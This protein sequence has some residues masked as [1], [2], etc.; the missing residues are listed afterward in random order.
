V[1]IDGTVDID[2]HR[3]LRG[4]D[5][6]PDGELL[7]GL[8][9]TGQA[10]FESWLV[11]Q[12]HRLA[13]LAEARL[14]ESAAGL[15]AAGEAAR[16]V[17]YAARMV[18]ANP[19][20]EGNHELLVRALAMAGDRAAALHQVAVCEDLFR[21]ELGVQPSPALRDAVDSG[22]AT[23][24]VPPISGRGAA[25]S[26]LEAGRA[27][28]LAGAVDA[29]IQ[30]LRRAVA[31][32]G[33]HGDAAL[34]ARCL[35]ALG[36]ALVHAVRGRDE[37]G[38]VVLR[39]AT[40]L[41]EQAGDRPTAVTA[42]RELGFVEVQA[43]RRSS[44]ESWLARA[45]ALAE[46]D[47]ELAPVLGI[48][49]MNASD[50]AD[51]AAAFVHL[52]ESVEAA[53]RAGDDRQAAWSLSILGRAHL[54]RGERSQ[55]AAAIT[56]SL[57]LVTRQRWLAFQPWPQALLGELD[58]AGGDREGAAE[59]LERAFS[60]ACQLGDPCWEGMAARGLGVLHADRGEHT[61]ATEWLSEAT[62]RCNRVPDRYV[63][64]LAYA[65]DGAVTH[66][67]EQHMYER[68]APLLANLAA[69]AARTDLR[70]LV[71]RAHLH[72]YR[73]GESAA[74]ASAR[75]LA[76]DIDNPALRAAL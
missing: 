16:A 74:L 62:A 10:E 3:L 64:V 63:W 60:L 71:V 30:C 33:R 72:R 69:L 27:A 4:T 22:P 75:L 20:D 70:E 39:E 68:A 65:L 46:T 76:A 61:A 9:L 40:V 73:M 19:L 34:R 6:P 29:G 18:A 32:A 52:G 67:I 14:R 11:V 58:L 51:Y 50:T 5:D 44:A 23:A 28:I 13:A 8:N 57:A 43:G 49:G 55:A 31:E 53:R 45:G 24:A 21:R 41:A 38:A 26:Q 37:E 12:R 47:E 56:E 35:A 48:R 2:L 1:T 36:S 15:L 54:L 17:P 59:H 25:L 42:H 7:E 66:A